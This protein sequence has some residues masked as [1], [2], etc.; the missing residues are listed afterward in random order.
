MVRHLVLRLDNLLV[1]LLRVLVFER[2][3]PANHRVEDHPAGPN[4]C[5][6]SVILLASDHLG[7]RV[8]RTA[9]SCLQFFARLVQIT[10][11]K[12]NNLDVVIVIEQQVL[13][14]QIS[15]DHSELVYVL[16]AAQDLCV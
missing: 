9:T 13:R 16:D 4:V 14:L 7:R 10:E 11:A 3:K 5:A 1:E 8:A 6:K 15:V 12:V 2:K